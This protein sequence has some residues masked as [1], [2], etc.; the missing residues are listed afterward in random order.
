MGRLT[1]KDLEKFKKMLQRRLEELTDNV[2][3]L[4]E[5]A[6]DPNGGG[7]VS[8]VPL[9]L[10]DVGTENFDKEFTLGIV[11]NEEEELQEIQDALKRIEEG[12]YGVC[13]SCGSPIPKT[14]LNALPFAR[15]CVKCQEEE[16]HS[17]PPVP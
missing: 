16:E 7:E 10:A 4:K 9:H 2:N 15:L 12:S 6:L 13:E 5:E 17:S 8:R 3:K 1:K 14:R 11:E